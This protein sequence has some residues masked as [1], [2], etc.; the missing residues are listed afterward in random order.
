M[1]PSRALRTSLTPIR[2]R[3][4]SVVIGFRVAD[5]Y[6]FCKGVGWT[7]GRENTLKNFPGKKFSGFCGCILKVHIRPP[8][9]SL[10]RVV[11]AYRL[12][13]L[14]NTDITEYRYTPIPSIPANPQH[15]PYGLTLPLAGRLSGI[16][17]KGN[18]VITGIGGRGE[19]GKG[20]RGGA[21][22]RGNQ[23]IGG[24]GGIG[25]SG[26]RGNRGDPPV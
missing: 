3:S 10:I 25:E 7:G 19:S 22:E 9:S 26:N 8:S 20:G 5:I 2:G 16:R 6:G 18:R 15:P 12:P 21:G 23:G 11:R 4:V 1:T 17:D 14:P 13:I 24:I